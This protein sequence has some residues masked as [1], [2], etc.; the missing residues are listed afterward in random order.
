MDFQLKLKQ[1]VDSLAELKAIAFCL[2]DDILQ[3][4]K[5]VDVS[6]GSCVAGYIFDYLSINVSRTEAINFAINIYVNSYSYN[7]ADDYYD[8]MID[9]ILSEMTEC[10]LVL[11]IE[12][13]NRNSQIYDRR[14]FY[15]SNLGIKKA[16]LKKNPQ[17]DYSPYTNFNR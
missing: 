17:F 14:K 3:H 4:A 12:G 5:S 16:M 15:S 13:S 9:P 1:K 11:L 2:S 7:L 10:Q 8:N 6:I